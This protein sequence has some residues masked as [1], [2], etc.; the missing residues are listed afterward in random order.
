MYPRCRQL[1]LRNGSKAKTPFQ[2]KFHRICDL[3]HDT[4]TGQDKKLCSNRRWQGW[5][6]NLLPIGIHSLHQV[7]SSWPPAFLLELLWSSINFALG[8][9]PVWV[10]LEPGW[11]LL[12]RISPLCTHY[13]QTGMSYSCSSTAVARSHLARQKP[14]DS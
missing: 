6:D 14:L 8:H 2:A 4:N 13:G 3:T 10:G 9:I 12:G 11:K 1:R 7:L 5:N